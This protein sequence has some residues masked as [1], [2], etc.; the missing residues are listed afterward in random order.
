MV[1]SDKEHS[2]TSFYLPS[3]SVQHPK[4]RHKPNA[5]NRLCV[6]WLSVTAE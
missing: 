6:K 3:C 5:R 4:N 2:T 1:A